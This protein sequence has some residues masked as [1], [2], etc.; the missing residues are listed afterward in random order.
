MG[1]LAIKPWVPFTALMVYDDSAATTWVHEPAQL[2][3]LLGVNGTPAVRAKRQLRAELRALDLSETT[4]HHEFD[5]VVQKHVQD[6]VYYED[7]K[8]AEGNVTGTQKKPNMAR[9]AARGPGSLSLDAR[10]GRR[11]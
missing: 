7:V 3:H 4:V 1:K 8:D 11:G 6:G 5:H 2:E 10:A 9:R